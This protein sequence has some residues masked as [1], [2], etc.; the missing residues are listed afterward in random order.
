M[1]ESY[2]RLLFVLSGRGKMSWRSFKQAFDTLLPLSGDEPSGQRTLVPKWALLNC[3]RML[4][5]MGH[6]D[7]DFDQGHAVFV[8]P[9]LLARL[10]RAGQ[11][12]AV[13]TGARTPSLVERLRVAAK[14]SRVRVRAVAPPKDT[15]GIPSSIFV[16]SASEARIRE[17][18][19]GIGVRFPP[20]PPAWQFAQF[21]G[22]VK[23]YLGSLNWVP[24]NPPDW[25][26]AGYDP[27][28]LRFVGL[29]ENGFR[30]R[31]SRHEVHGR[32]TYALWRNGCRATA[33]LDWARHAIA[34]QLS[35][36]L[37]AYDPAA[38]VF[39]V[40]SATPIPKPLSRALGLCSGYPPT[41]TSSPG[42]AV[43]IGTERR[44]FDFF[45]GVPMAIAELVAAKLGQEFIQAKCRKGELIDG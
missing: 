29:C 36:Q 30:L 25:S 6:C 39:G 26:Q 28:R 8:A 21:A 41:R 18:A 9:P 1:H 12:V 33:N 31:L 23:Q 5:S 11:V 37:V 19:T 22:S 20:E 44:V 14:T 3:V 13:L 15:V 4:E 2:D 42:L 10:P 27:I 16:E 7:F 40:P 17:L 45:R 35:Q 24:T 43:D 38:Q 34:S 32:W